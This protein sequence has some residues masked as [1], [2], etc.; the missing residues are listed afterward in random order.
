MGQT[1]SKAILLVE[2]A[3]AHKIIPDPM[4]KAASQN[5]IGTLPSDCLLIRHD[6]REVSIEDSAAL[7]CDRDGKVT[8]WRVN[9][10]GETTSCGTQAVKHLS[11]S[12]SS[13]QS[14]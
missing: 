5:R 3:K 8:L 7:I 14:K 11:V 12:W 6:G 1:P 4:G 2:H 9:S 13:P 10:S